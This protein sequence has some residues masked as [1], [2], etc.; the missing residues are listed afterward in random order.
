MEPAGPSPAAASSSSDAGGPGSG[1]GAQE[2]PLLFEPRRLS[3]LFGERE[4]IGSREVDAGVCGAFSPFSVSI[5][6]PRSSIDAAGIDVQAR[7]NNRKVPVPSP[8]PHFTTAL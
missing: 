7:P 5:R 1:S 4:P 6:H 2:S 3:V 8:T